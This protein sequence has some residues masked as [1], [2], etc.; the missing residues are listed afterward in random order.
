MVTETP[1]TTPVT[2]LTQTMDKVTRFLGA[3]VVL[4]LDDDTN[5]RT[6]L[7]LAV[8]PTVE[9]QFAPLDAGRTAT[10]HAT[11]NGGWGVVGYPDWDNQQVMRQA[12]GALRQAADD[13]EAAANNP[14]LWQDATPPIP[15]TP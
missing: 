7:V 13:I 14:V 8:D 4:G 2:T 1:D 12:S 15:S 3:Y 9:I 11:H 10:V 6:A 5:G